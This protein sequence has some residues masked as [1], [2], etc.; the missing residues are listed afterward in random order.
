M[1]IPAWVSPGSPSSVAMPKSVST[2]R[3]SRLSSTLL[4]LTSRCRMPAWCAQCSALSSLLPRSADCSGGSG[5][6]S[7]STCSSE[8]ASTSSITI[9][10]QPSAS[11]T[12]KTV[13]TAGWFSR[14]AVLASR[15]LRS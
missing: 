15:R 8:R 9:Q 1:T 5:P 3:P 10:G 13:T 14:A 6:S 12:S 2:A 7:A 11:M 4:G